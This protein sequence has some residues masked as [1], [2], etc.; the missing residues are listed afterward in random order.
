MDN[1]HLNLAV[2]VGAQVQL[3]KKV[4]PKCIWVENY[5]TSQTTLW[6]FLDT[7]M[8]VTLFLTQVFLHFIYHVLDW[9][10]GLF[11]VCSDYFS[12]L[13]FLWH[14]AVLSSCAVDKLLYFC[15]HN[16]SCSGICL[17]RR[18]QTFES[19]GTWRGCFKDY[20]V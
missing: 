14:A 19:G 16:F 18:T 4:F 12:V 8:G 5:Y 11:V 3:I 20:T 13:V 2:V 9:N 1:S 10:T 15:R 7:T 6:R 17:G